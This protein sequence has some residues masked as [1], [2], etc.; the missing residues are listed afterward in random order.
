VPDAAANGGANDLYFPRKR[1]E[2]LGDKP[3]LLFIAAANYRLLW[4]AYVVR[5]EST[6][7]W[8]QRWAHTS[9][10]NVVIMD[11]SGHWMPNHFIRGGR[12][13]NGSMSWPSRGNLAPYSFGFYGHPGSYDEY[14][15]KLVY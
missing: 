4:P 12:D 11:G 14:F 5:G 15:E 7:I 13:I 1:F 8:R 6:N 9:G 2:R 3:V 10:G